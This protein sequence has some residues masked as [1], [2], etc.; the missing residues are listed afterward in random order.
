MKSI[1]LNVPAASEQALRDGQVED[2]VV[3][4]DGHP[5]ALVMPFDEDDLEWYARERDS[6]FIDSIARA[7]EQAAAG[8]T[9]G[10]ED[11]RKQLGVE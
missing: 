5:V 1:E 4:R 6:G 11:L 8:Q 2:V 3:L 7:R 10:H 9:I